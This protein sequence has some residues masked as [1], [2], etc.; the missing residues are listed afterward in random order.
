MRH[1]T[2]GI[3]NT[4]P[5]QDLIGI[6]NEFHKLYIAKHWIAQNADYALCEADLSLPFEENYFAGMICSNSF[7]F[8]NNKSLCSR[9]LKRITSD[10]GQIIITAIRHDLHKY[11]N[12]KTL[13]IKCYQS[14]FK[15]FPLRIVPDSMIL[16]RY[17]R[18]TGPALKH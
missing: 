18:K 6:D 9:E 17:L 1:I 15:D 3:K 12:Q 14:L 11:Q 8:F 13:S 2:R 7:H 5:G 16:S 10:S 4:H